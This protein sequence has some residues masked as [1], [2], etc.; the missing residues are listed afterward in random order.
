[1]PAML[2]LKSVKETC[3]MMKKTRFMAATAVALMSSTAVQ[4]QSDELVLYCSVGEEWCRVM[5]EAFERE[6][7]IDV[8]MTRKSSGRDLCPDQGRGRPAARRRVVGRH[9]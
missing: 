5:S 9:R 8:L 1:M 7:G 6:T 2:N 3:K 4:A